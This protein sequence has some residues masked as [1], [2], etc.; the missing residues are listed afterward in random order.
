MAKVASNDLSAW[1]PQELFYLIEYSSR[2]IFQ[3]AY[4]FI[5][6]K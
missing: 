4:N 6:N 1:L 5:S 3:Y 2:H